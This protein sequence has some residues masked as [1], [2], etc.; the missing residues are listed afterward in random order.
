MLA[1]NL[2]QE[3]LLLLKQGIFS[4][5]F[6]SFWLLGMIVFTLAITLFPFIYDYLH[7]SALP[8]QVWTVI[9]IVIFASTWWIEL[10]KFVS[11]A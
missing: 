9:L 3:K 6:G 7:T 5:R 11:K 1:L 10:S 4:N 8:I 2:K